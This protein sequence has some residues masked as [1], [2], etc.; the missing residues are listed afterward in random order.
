[1]ALKVLMVGYAHVHA[2]GYTE[3]LLK[4]QAEAGDV[5]LLG[6]LDENE[7]RGRYY[8][9]KYNLRFF[10]SV[11]EALEEKPD[12]FIINSE[13][14]KHSAYVKLA[15]EDNIHVFC[16]KPIGVNLKDA[17]DI[18][19]VVK[20]RGI[21][22][23]TGFN[24]RFNPEN[25]K[26]R[27][28][29]SSGELGKINVVRVRVAHSAAIDKWFKGWSEWFTVEEMAGGGGFLDLC[30]HGADLLRYILK[31]EA[32]EATGFINNFTSNYNIDDQGIGLIKFSSG[33][34]GILDGGWTQVVEGISWLPLEVY[35][36]KGSLIRTPIGLTY[37]T[38]AQKGWIKP[39]L[40]R[41]SRNS[42]DEFIG[43][44]KDDKDPPITVDDAI[45]A[46]EII[47]AVYVSSK[48]REIIK[49]PLANNL[50]S[51]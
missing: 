39:N 4:R 12:A 10:R 37:Y 26:A 2:P 18:G 25:I 36:D 31:D 19:A 38:R 51:P 23:T 30:I 50:S 11:S 8:A 47:E 43:A 33:A 27:E 46:Q 24:A 45:K 17:L 13:T 35:G 48:R 6:I 29:V 21:K 41:T 15:A 44:I 32:V 16:E 5:K 20:R 14:V 34:L 42:L 7:E 3:Q 9:N 28:I 22:F 1:M 40:E 49:L